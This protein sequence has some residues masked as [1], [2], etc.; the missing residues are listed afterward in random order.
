[1]IELKISKGEYLTHKDLEKYLNEYEVFLRDSF[2]K[3]KMMEYDWNEFLISHNN[4]IERQISQ[5]DKI[6]LIVENVQK[7]SFDGYPFHKNT[8]YLRGEE[9]VGDWKPYTR[10]FLDNVYEIEFKIIE[11]KN[12]E[13]PPFKEDTISEYSV[14]EIFFIK[15]T[16]EEPRKL[17]RGD[18]FLFNIN[19]LKSTR[20]GDNDSK[21]FIFLEYFDKTNIL[22]PSTSSSNSNCFVVTTTMGDINHPVVNDFR[23]YRDDVLLNT[24]LGRIF[25]NLYYQIGPYLSEIIKN[26]KT[27]F[28]IS[29]SFI[30]KLHKRIIKK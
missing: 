14:P 24:I 15:L 11:I 27:L 4:N 2:K 18:K 7:K 5:F 21:E 29:R 28:Q 22:P 9:S 13:T 30:L 26:N 8:I 1:M 25:I 16:T 23:N 12:P 6:E 10:Q 17:K 20:F 3:D 19:I